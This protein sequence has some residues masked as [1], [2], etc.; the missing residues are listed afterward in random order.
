MAEIQ[1]KDSGERKKGQQ[2]KFQIHVDFTPMVDMNMLLITFFMLCTTMSKP[3]TMEIS[4]PRKDVVPE[5]EQNKVKESKAITVLLGMDS[6][7]YYYFGKPD[8]EHPESVTET[9][10]SADGLRKVLIGRNEEVVN[11]IREIKRKK[12]N[13][14]ISEEEYQNQ[15]AEIR[16]DKNSPVVMIKATEFS[17][18][19][20]LIDALDEMQICNIGRYAIADITPGDL[21]V[22]QDL[23]H[24]GYTSDLKEV[25]IERETPQ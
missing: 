15:A 19:K 21:R 24:A 20:D 5:Q 8:Y 3:Q 1:E 10:F 16:A 6:K 2:K 9:D 14:E 23:T 7:V 17:K 22:L 25:V 18:Y 12:D 11:K 4:M 13:L